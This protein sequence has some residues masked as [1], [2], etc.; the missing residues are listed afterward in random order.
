MTRVP[1]LVVLMCM[2]M[3]FLHSTYTYSH[4][5]NIISSISIPFS[6]QG[7]WEIYVF[8]L[9]PTLVNRVLGTK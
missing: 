6:T 8:K 2:Y 5:C 7:T 3:Y 9:L 4:T 1:L